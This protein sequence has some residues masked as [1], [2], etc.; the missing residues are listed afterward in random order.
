MH[1]SPESVHVQV[2][3]SE[4]EAAQE[5]A[6]FGTLHKQKQFKKKKKFQDIR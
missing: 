6:K 5:N 3:T 2:T 1:I 4:V